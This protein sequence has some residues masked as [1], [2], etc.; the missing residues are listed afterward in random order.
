MLLAGPFTFPF[1]VGTGVAPD[2]VIKSTA[3]THG[4]VA[5]HHDMPVVGFHA[6]QKPCL[7]Q[8]KSVFD[9]D[10]CRALESIVSPGYPGLCG[11]DCAS[12]D[13]FTSWPKGRNSQRVAPMRPR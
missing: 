13:G 6:L 5:Q 7:G 4:A 12:F 2:G 11:Q 8:I 1:A 9:H 3:A 10:G